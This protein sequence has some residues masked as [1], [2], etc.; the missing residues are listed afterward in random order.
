MYYD[1]YNSRP[2]QAKKKS[3]ADRPRKRMKFGQTWW[4]AEWLNALSHID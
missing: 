3:L 1:W 2:R 4:G